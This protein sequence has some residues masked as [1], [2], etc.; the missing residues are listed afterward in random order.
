MI[1]MSND[2]KITY[3]LLS[4]HAALST[5]ADPKRPSSNQNVRTEKYFIAV[6]FHRS[7][8]QLSV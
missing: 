2:S 3:V 1:N 8:S 4:S 5:E 7:L 6:V